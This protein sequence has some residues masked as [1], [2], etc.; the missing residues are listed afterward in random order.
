MSLSEAVTQGSECET[1]CRLQVE[2]R[3]EP[4]QRGQLTLTLQQQTVASDTEVR[5]E[6]WSCTGVMWWTI[7]LM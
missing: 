6:E 4:G 5:L 1:S 7:I 3:Q 2:C